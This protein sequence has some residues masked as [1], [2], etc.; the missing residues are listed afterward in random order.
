[1]FFYN[2]DVATANI[3]LTLVVNETVFKVSPIQNATDYNVKLSIVKDGVQE[4]QGVLVNI[5][6]SIFEFNLP[7][8]YTNTKGKYTGE[9]EVSC[10]VDGQTEKITSFPIEYEVRESITTK[11][12]M[13]EQIKE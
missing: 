12:K 13:D 3:Y 1:M 2:T 8:N 5:Q 6:Q 4:L 9:F 7:A 11:F 10:L